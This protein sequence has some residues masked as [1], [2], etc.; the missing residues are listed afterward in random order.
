MELGS[1]RELQSN[2]AAL[3]SNWQMQ[4]STHIGEVL[5]NCNLIHNRI[6]PREV[7]KSDLADPVETC[8]EFIEGQTL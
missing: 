2:L 6:I 5:L 1:N 7:T 3:S 8:P 4:K